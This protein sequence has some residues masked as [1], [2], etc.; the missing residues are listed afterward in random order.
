MRSTVGLRSEASLP[1][2]ALF[3]F[4]LALGWVCIGSPPADAGEVPDHLACRQLSDSELA[5]ARVT[6]QSTLEGAAERSCKLSKAAFLCSPAARISTVPTP[7]LDLVDA[8]ELPGEF[9]CYR[10]RCRNQA[11]DEL[12]TDAFGERTVK[13][14]RSSLVCIPASLGDHL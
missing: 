6:L 8:A 13:I 12:V 7:P 1:T 11:R 9:L 4:V 3:C 2:R 5:R 14:G 10:S